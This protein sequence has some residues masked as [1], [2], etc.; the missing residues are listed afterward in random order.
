MRIRR[1]DDEEDPVERRVSTCSADP[2]A[3]AYS[4]DRNPTLLIALR[5]GYTRS[6]R[7]RSWLHARQ[8]GNYH[9]RADLYGF[10]C[11]SHQGDC[12]RP[13]LEGVQSESYCVGYLLFDQEDDILIFS[14]DDGSNEELYLEPGVTCCTRI[15]LSI[16][17]LPLME[18]ARPGVSVPLRA[19]S[20]LLAYQTI[21]DSDGCG[22]TIDSEEH[23]DLMSELQRLAGTA[24]DPVVQELTRGPAKLFPASNWNSHVK[25][26]TPEAAH[27]MPWR[28]LKKMMTNKYCLRGEIKK[29]EFEMWNLKV[30]EIDQVKKY[31]GGL[32]DTIHGSVMAT[33]PKTMQDAIEFATELMDKKINTWAERQADNKRKSDDTARNN[34]NQQSKT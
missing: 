17:A 11:M 14:L 18:V 20:W 31:V 2:A 5:L 32:P 13:T 1:C 23:L 29:L 21:E 8:V 30:K 24:K 34:Q 27:A 25:T 3:V 4:A 28:T 26:T 6:G 16:D 22:G 15:G 10:A 33:K 19:L 12:I 7:V 9:T